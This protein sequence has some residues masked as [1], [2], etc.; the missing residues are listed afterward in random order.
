MLASKK[1]SNKAVTF[2]TPMGAQR[3]EELP[4]GDDWLYELKLGWFTR[5]GNSCFAQTSTS[6]TRWRADR[7]GSACNS[8]SMPL[9]TSDT[10]IFRMSSLRAGAVRSRRSRS[11]LG[12]HA[13]VAL[14][15]LPASPSDCVAWQAF[16]KEFRKLRAAT[17]L[18]L[19]GNLRWHA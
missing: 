15:D 8:I 6:Q 4:E 2:I 5:R 18:H 1:S 13:A 10:S 17:N 11:D 16:E 14:I 19:P 3:V 9:V 12:E 7:L